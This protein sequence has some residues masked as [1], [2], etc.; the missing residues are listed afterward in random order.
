[1]ILTGGPSAWK[2]QMKKDE[3]MKLLRNPAEYR[4]KKQQ[5]AAQAAVPS[6]AQVQARA[7]K[8]RQ[9]TVLLVFDAN[10]AGVLFERQEPRGKFRSRVGSGPVAR[11]GFKR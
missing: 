8:K 11:L 9:D 10:H 5:A 1:M 3:L 7:E 6:A 4:K 2:K